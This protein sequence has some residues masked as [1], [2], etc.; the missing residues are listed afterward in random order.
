[1][2]LVCW[3]VVSAL[4]WNSQISAK[5]KFSG[6][7]S[8]NEID[9]LCLQETKL[10]LDAINSDRNKE[11]INPKGYESFHAVSS[12]KSGYSGVSTWCKL[13]KAFS[14]T[15][16]TD[17]LMTTKEFQSEGR[18]IVTQHGQWFLLC[19]VY[20]PNAGDEGKR[21][22]FKLSFLR[23]MLSQLLILSKER[24]LP[25]VIVGDFNIAHRKIDIHPAL[26]SQGDEYHSYSKEEIDIID[27]FSNHWIDTF[28][29]QFPTLENVY[30]VFDRRTQSRNYNQGARIDYIF[31][32]KELWVEKQDDSVSPTIRVED[33]KDFNKASTSAV[34]NTSMSLSD[35]L[36][37]VGVLDDSLNPVTAIVDESSIP[38]LSSRKLSSFKSQKESL[39]AMFKPKSATNNPE[40]KENRATNETDYGSSSKPEVTGIQVVASSLDYQKLSG[41]KR[42]FA[43]GRS[44]V[45]G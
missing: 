8:S 44:S 14:V 32:P 25:V 31:A 36:A 22:E 33:L 39:M 16:S 29:L 3:N 17:K 34:V 15:W 12:I 41:T 27:E 24:G 7:L 6:W 5:S 4:P 26:V 20:V 21:L 9:V 2:K 37:I 43:S 1:M 35:H 23:E 11:L 40:E 45:F 28:R 10:P 30:T 19:N 18:V 38:P 42:P 13:N